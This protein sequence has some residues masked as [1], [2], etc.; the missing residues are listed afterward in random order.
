MIPTIPPYATCYPLY[1]HDILHYP[2]CYPYAI[3]MISPTLGRSE[4]TR[5]PEEANPGMQRHVSLQEQASSSGNQ[6]GMGHLTGNPSA[7]PV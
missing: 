6:L 3:P 2:Y 4:S 7:V 5:T 1:P